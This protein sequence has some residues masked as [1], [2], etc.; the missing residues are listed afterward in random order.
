MVLEGGGKCLNS[1]YIRA[2]YTICRIYATA[3]WDLRQCSVLLLY[4]VLATLWLLK[5]CLTWKNCRGY[6][7]V[8]LDILLIYNTHT[9]IHTYMH[10]NT[11]EYFRVQPEIPF[12]YIDTHTLAHKN[13]GVLESGIWYPLYIHTHMHTNAYLN[14][15][16]HN[17]YCKLTCTHS[18]EYTYRL[19][20]C[21]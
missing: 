13:Q 18:L 16:M 17:K 14:I 21:P 1:R 19:Q 15:Y 3:V 2:I 11:K 12:V 8:Q 9:H 7:R 4:I 20:V 10:T 6:Y 5:H